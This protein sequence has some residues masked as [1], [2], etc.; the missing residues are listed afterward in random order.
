VHDIAVSTC[1]LRKLH[2][3]V[4]ITRIT[5]SDTKDALVQ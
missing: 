2:V 5:M 4:T 1:Y 3:F